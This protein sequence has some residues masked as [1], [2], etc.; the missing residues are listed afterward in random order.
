MYIHVYTYQDSTYW[1]VT[2]TDRVTIQNIPN[3][4][5]LVSVSVYVDVFCWPK[6]FLGLCST[7]VGKSC[8]SWFVFEL[9]FGSYRVCG[10]GNNDD[11]AAV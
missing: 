9:P 8:L 2:G 6:R 5:P 7:F 3:M 11:G 10:V 1:R 4:L